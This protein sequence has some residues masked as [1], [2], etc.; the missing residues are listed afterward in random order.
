MISDLHFGHKW[1]AHHR[2][3]QDEFYQDEHIVEQWNKVVHKKDLVYILGDVTM[4]SKEHYYRF[5][6]MNGRKVVV[7]GNHHRWQDTA[8][9]LKYVDG[10]AGVISYKGF[11]LTH[12]PVHSKELYDNDFKTRWRGNIHGHMHEHTLDDKMYFNVSAERLDYTPILFTDILKK[13]GKE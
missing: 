5:N 3:F 10:V 4:E 13:M 9:L 8:E 12:I 7:L 6:T 1:M 11:M 2:G